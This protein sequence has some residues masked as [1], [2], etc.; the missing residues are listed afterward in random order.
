ML[1]YKVG[2]IAGFRMIYSG[3]IETLN[4]N[5]ISMKHDLPSFAL[6]IDADNVSKESIAPIIEEITRHG[7]LTVK[8]VYGDFTTPNLAGWRETLAN[9]GIHPIQQYRNSTGKN[10]SDSALIID[11]MDLLHSR[12]FDGFALVSSDGDFTRLAT[13]IREDGL[14]VYGFGRQDAAK[15]FVQACDTYIFIQNLLAPPPLPGEDLPDESSGA[16][17]GNTSADS[18]VASSVVPNASLPKSAGTPDLKRLNNLLLRA[19]TNVTNEDGWALVSRM[20]QYLRENHSE[21]NPSNY[22]ASTFF[23]LLG[24]MQSFAVA[25]RKQGNGHAQFCQPRKHKTSN[26]PPQRKSPSISATRQLTPP[27]VDALKA[28]VA[29]CGNAEQWA[30]IEDIRAHLNNNGIRL[31]ESG[32]A[33]LAE[34]I[35]AT[36][37]FDMCDAG[38]ANKIYRLASGKSLP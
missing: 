28:A 17:N 29:A 31:D 35:Q 4:S 25:Q 37:L 38:G 27:Y 34:A 32:F 22:G 13:R 8:R 21:L 36:K 6:L 16:A 7:R 11:A 15:A 30:N 20:E 9:H 10:A 1:A 18:T 3:K 12:R 14:A 26:P 5:C 2:I 23:K 24:R 33:S 19:Y